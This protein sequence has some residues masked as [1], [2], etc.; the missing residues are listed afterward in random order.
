[1]GILLWA[2]SLPNIR[3]LFQLWRQAYT[4]ALTPFFPL[5]Y[6]MSEVHPSWI[7]PVQF[8]AAGKT[9]DLPSAVCRG[10]STFHNAATMQGFTTVPLQKQPHGAL[11]EAH[12]VSVP[13]LRHLKAIPRSPSSCHGGWE[14]DLTPKSSAPAWQESAWMT[15]GLRHGHLCFGPNS[16][17][18]W[19]PIYEPS[20]SIAGPV[21]LHLHL[22]QYQHLYRH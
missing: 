14:Q 20:C 2:L 10:S 6:K 17:W 8:P 5:D 21:H 19:Y 1:M 12:N 16:V 9:P 4:G 22:L 13:G 11:C 7:S 15:T 3:D 18:I